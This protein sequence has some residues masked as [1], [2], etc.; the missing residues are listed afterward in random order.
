M[1]MPLSYLVGISYI[2]YFLGNRSVFKSILLTEIQSCTI[3]F[4]S[5]QCFL[6]SVFSHY[7]NLFQV[8]FFFIFSFVENKRLVNRRLVFKLTS[9]LLLCDLN[10]ECIVKL[11]LVFRLLMRRVSFRRSLIWIGA[12]RRKLELVWNP[13]STCPFA[14]TSR[15]TSS[16]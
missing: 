11:V 13:N 5:P 7:S 6:V 12:H 10:F 4:F 9:V 15:T 3:F 1:V 16:R 2:Y 8:F 14:F